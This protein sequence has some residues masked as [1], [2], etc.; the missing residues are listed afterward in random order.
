MIK[1]AKLV[2]KIPLIILLAVSLFLSALPV[3]PVSAATG[4]TLSTYTGSPGNTVTI[5]GT[6]DTVTSGAA[7][8]T[9]NDIYIGLAPISSGS[10][11]SNFQVPVLPRGKYKVNVSVEG[12]SVSLS[13]EFTIKPS[14]SISKSTV[15]VGEQIA[16]SGSGFS[17][18]NIS[19]YMDNAAT[20]L[21]IA[22]ADDTGILNTVIFTV[23][24]ANKATHILKAIDITGATGA[25][26]TTFNIIPS[27]ALSE[28][29]GGAGAQITITGYGFASSS[30]ITITLNSTALPTASIVTDINGTFIATATLP[31]SIAKGNYT[32]MAAD[33]TGNTATGNLVIRQ[34]LSIS[35]ESG[36][37]ND[38]IT[39]NGTSFDANKSIS[40]LFNNTVLASAQTD[41]YGA[42]SAVL[43]IPLVAQGEYVIKAIDANGNEAIEHFSVVPSIL[44]NPVIEKV[45]NKITINGSGFFSTSNVAI[46]FN[47]VNIGNART[48]SLGTFSIDVLVPYS[49]SGEHQIK[50][51]DEHDN[52]SSANFT[53]I[54][55]ISL[56]YDTGFVGDAIIISGTGFAAGSSVSNM[57]TFTIGTVP[58]VMNEGNIFTD[59]NG[60]FTASFNIP[61]TIKGIHVITAIDAFGNT[62]NSAITVESSISSNTSTGIAGEEIQISGSGFAPNK[63]IDIK[64]N[65]TIMNTSPGTVTTSINGSFIASFVLPNITAGTY[66]ILASDGINSGAVNFTQI[67]ESVPPPAVS[68]ISPIDKTKTSQPVIFNWNPS[69]DPSG[70]FYQIQVGT[71]AAFSTL[72]LDVADLTA[73]TYTMNAEYR[74]DSVNVKNPYYWRVKAIDG[75]GNESTWVTDTFI[76]GSGWPDW[77]TYA[78]IGIGGFII[79]IL[80]GFWIGRRMAMKHSDSSYNYNMDASEDTDD[81]DIEYRYRKQYPNINLDHNP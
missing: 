68:L 56:D 3:S 24:A 16:I 32:I 22:N 67:Y 15:T 33:S 38:T 58:L 2:F 77:L 71:D 41:A 36:F 39:I 69:S 50:A 6:F 51:I 45:D 29:T 70:I 52:Q 43:T 35:K 72:L 34:T 60:S 59:I 10:F 17:T 28:E 5:S 4:I 21:M 66:V 62:D 27:I 14:I 57:V 46:Y 49:P 55:G 42:F 20:P 44:I 73:T 1:K 11:T 61:E 8:I 48:N 78:L 23:P 79:L 76:V 40:I 65:N 53:T 31:V 63:K 12:S 25:V 54:P 18:G 9:F 26:Y 7:I 80:S 13:E 47:N 81:T 37:V 75:V 19:I 64:Y 30:M 74:F